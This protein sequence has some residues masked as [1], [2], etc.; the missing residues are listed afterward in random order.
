MNSFRDAALALSVDITSGVI[1]SVEF[2]FHFN[3]VNAA[4]EISIWPQQTLGNIFI[5]EHL[6]ISSILLNVTVGIV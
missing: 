6:D 4:S 3:H 5:D 1:R 2:L